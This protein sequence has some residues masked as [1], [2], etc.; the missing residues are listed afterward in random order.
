M[1]SGACVGWLGR[2][3]RARE[4]GL[5]AFLGA[6]QWWRREGMQI[7]A[8]AFAMGIKGAGVCGAAEGCS[9]AACRPG[10][11]SQCVGRWCC[12]G[13][14]GSAEEHQRCGSAWAHWI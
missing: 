11:G 7:N 13:A 8:G 1:S 10:G 2:C 3:A 6:A 9:A 14:A 4:E 5:F 12:C